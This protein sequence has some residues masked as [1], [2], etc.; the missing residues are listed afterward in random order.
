MEYI[1]L[2]AGELT[3]ITI[4]NFS[5]IEIAEVLDRKIMS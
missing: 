1:E 4:M 3:S 5:Y 2:Y